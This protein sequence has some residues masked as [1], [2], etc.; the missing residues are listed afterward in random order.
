[1]HLTTSNRAVVWDQTVLL[2][3]WDL[4]DSPPIEWFLGVTSFLSYHATTKRLVKWHIS[5]EHSNSCKRGWGACLIKERIRR[6]KVTGTTR[7]C[8]QFTSK[9]KEHDNLHIWDSRSKAKFRDS[10]TRKNWLKS[11][12]IYYTTVSIEG[13][14]KHRFWSCQRERSLP[15]TPWTWK[16]A[17]TFFR[18]WAEHV[19]TSRLSRCNVFLL[20]P[21]PPHILIPEP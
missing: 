8:E 14:C 17:I 1:M 10:A 18:L 13:R 11:R 19:T 5:Y 20:Y 6:D 16:I 2:K 21:R 3:L 15:V 7:L 12:L 4:R 9:N